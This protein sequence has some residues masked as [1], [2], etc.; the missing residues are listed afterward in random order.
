M[1]FKHNGFRNVF[2]K[3]F[4]FIFLLGSFLTFKTLNNFSSLR[5]LRSFYSAFAPVK[6]KKI[7]IFLSYRVSP[8][9]FT[10]MH[11]LWP[12]S[13]KRLSPIRY[14]F[15]LVALFPTSKSVISSVY[16]R[17]MLAEDKRIATRTVF[18]TFNFHNAL[19]RF[20]GVIYCV[21]AR[22][23]HVRSKNCLKA[24]TLRG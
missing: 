24:P 4:N 3:N 20:L 10:G 9:P 19:G 1:S 7:S 21:N 5:V 17:D 13:K 8:V 6:W 16:T 18:G 11:A 14:V 23:P 15:R 12:F 22:S 2:I